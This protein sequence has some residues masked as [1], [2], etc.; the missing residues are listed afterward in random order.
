MI[1]DYD[2]RK[3]LKNPLGSNKMAGQARLKKEGFKELNDF[4]FF[5]TRAKALEAIKE[6]LPSRKKYDIIIVRDKFKGSS[7]GFVYTVWYKS[8]KKI[9]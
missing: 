8:I 5:E 9:K 4:N 2:W 1:R 6:F 3:W 7:S